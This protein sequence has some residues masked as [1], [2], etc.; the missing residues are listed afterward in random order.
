M[1]TGTSQVFKQDSPNLGR[2]LLFDEE[3]RDLCVAKVNVEIS[4]F[5]GDVLPLCLIPLLLPWWTRRGFGVLGLICTIS[6]DKN[7]SIQV[8]SAT[9]RNQHKSRASVFRIYIRGG[10]GGWLRSSKYSCGAG[11]ADAARCIVHDEVDE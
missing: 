1:W 11:G 6:T 3:A 4:N 10:G 9:W 2:D 8:Y 5:L 7:E